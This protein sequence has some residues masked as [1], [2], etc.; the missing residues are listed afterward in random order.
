MRAADLMPGKLGLAGRLPGQIDEL[1]GPVSGVVL[2]PRNLSLPGMRECDIGDDTRR[3]AMYSLL[4][5]QGK[6]NDIVRLVNPQL[7]SQDWATL[8]K[9]LD[10][11]LRR[12]CERQLGLGSQSP[13][14]AGGR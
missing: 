9:A 1:R 8:S 11:R 5:T 7:L 6:H 12:R 10:S 2:L 14:Q 13:A 4:L 3:R